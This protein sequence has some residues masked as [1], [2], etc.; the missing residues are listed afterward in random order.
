M[1]VTNVQQ[2]LAGLT[3]TLTAEFAA[4]IE[5]VWEMWANPRLLERWWGPPT[6]PAT[7]EEHEL[8]PGGVVR[9]FMT[10]PEGE[11]FHGWWKVTACEA[12]RRLEFEDG[13]GH[14]P[15]DPASGMP[16]TA[17]RVTIGEGDGGATRMTIHATFPSADAMERLIA[18][19]M[20]DGIRA[21][22][23]QID[24]LIANLV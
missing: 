7:V 12:P 23:G 8:V 2:D 22:V 14:S 9:Y 3:M 4:P 20:E 18:M 11:Q 17:T 1:T 16:I 5:R 15:S 13:F 6:Y 21:A 24:D 19:G 10:S